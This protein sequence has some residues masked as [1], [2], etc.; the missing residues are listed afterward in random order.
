MLGATEN[1]QVDYFLVLGT[2]MNYLGSTNRF[3]HHMI[4]T[5]DGVAMCKNVALNVLKL[6]RCTKNSTFTR[7]VLMLNNEVLDKIKLKLSGFY[8]EFR[9]E[10]PSKLAPLSSYLL[11]DSS[12]DALLYLSHLSGLRVSLLLKDA[13]NPDLLQCAAYTSYCGLPIRRFPHQNSDKPQKSRAVFRCNSL[14]SF[15]CQVSEQGIIL[16]RESIRDMPFELPVLSIGPQAYVIFLCSYMCQFGWSRLSESSSL[17]Q[18][19]SLSA[20]EG[21]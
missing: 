14:S 20:T 5:F 9:C 8:K 19:E 10:P 2:T 16:S 4:A 18:L 17:G 21:K 3:K 12:P 7:L 13:S 1:F 6:V 15:F 11:L